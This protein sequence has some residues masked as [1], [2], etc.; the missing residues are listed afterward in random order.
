MTTRIAP[1]VGA[2]LLGQ[3]SAERNQDATTYVGN[4]DPQVSEELL[5][6]LF[7][8]A[9]PVVNVYVPKDRVTNLH[10]GYG[11]VEFRSEE[12]ADYAIKILNMLKLYGKPIRVNKASQD[13]KSLDVGANLFIGNL[14]PEV[15]EKL[16]YD[17]FSAFG[18]IVTNPKIMRDPET[19]NSRGFGF[20]SYDSFESSDQAI[21]AMNNQHLCNRPITVSYAYKKDT[22]GER[23]GTPAERLLA[24]NNPGSQ[25]H[26]PHTMFATAPP[27][28]GL[29]NGGVSAP[30]PR[31]FANGNVQGQI[32]HVRLPPPPIG[33]Y[34]P[35]MQM[36]GQ[37]AW[38]GPP[39]M[40]M[41]PPMQQQLQYRLPGMPP[42]QNV[43]PPPHHMARPPPPPPNMQ[44]P[45]MWRPPPPPQ[46]AGGM[47]PPP[48]SMPPPPPPPSG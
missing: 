24:A 40:Q 30:V 33:Q 7:V 8:Q 46:H 22:K 11:F 41:P 23:H 18:V 45:P 44:A 36:H 34:P 19:G 10:Q 2:N 12:D 27:T 29:Q 32:Q 35:Q 5:W 31:P 14:D 15:D 38:P 13:K 1:G 43:M 6:E 28:Q 48:M 20:V 16:L 9:G 39:N 21:E 17:T 42:P 47:P 3:H 37:P 26:R 25:K 4:L